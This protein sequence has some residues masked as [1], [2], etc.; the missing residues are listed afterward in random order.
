M[1][2]KNALKNKKALLFDCDDTLALT[3]NAHKKA[4]ELA[5]NLHGV[6]FDEREFDIYA[7]MGGNKLMRELVIDAGYPH[8]V[9]QIIIDKQRF[10]TPCL[11]KLMV[12]NEELINLIRK[13]HGNLFIA[14]VS[15]GRKKSIEQVLNVLDIRYHVQV[16]ITKE[17]VFNSKPYA[18]PYVRAIE[19][20]GVKPED[21]IAFE[22]NDI[23]IASA[24]SAGIKDIV[25]VT[26]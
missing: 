6:P 10:L 12:P 2:N 3:M 4:Y 1:L 11:E 9:Q 16:L 15:N 5:F 18:E 23:G 14:V 8:L 25:K 7:P 22:D 21:C 13:Q 19:I 17:H 20:L 24:K 26:I